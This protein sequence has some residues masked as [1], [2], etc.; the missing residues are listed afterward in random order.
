MHLLRG[1]LP[2]HLDVILISQKHSLAAKWCPLCIITQIYINSQIRL[3]LLGLEEM[4][5]FHGHQEVLIFPYRF[6]IYLIIF[7]YLE[8]KMYSNVINT[9]N[10][11]KTRYEKNSSRLISSQKYSCVYRENGYNFVLFNLGYNKT[12]GPCSCMFL[13]FW[14]I[15]CHTIQISYL[16]SNNLMLLHK[17]QTGELH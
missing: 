13:N 16:K 11:Q 17:I 1:E 3:F 15:W 9:R 6:L 5:Q 7:Y 8:N 2:D 12:V 10:K 4:I 14:F